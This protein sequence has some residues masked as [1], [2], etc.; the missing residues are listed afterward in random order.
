MVLTLTINKLHFPNNGT[1]DNPITV[2]LYYKEYYGSDYTLIG[3]GYNVDVDGTITDSPLPTISVNTDLKYVL[4]AV[5]ELCGFD[6]EQPVIINPYCPVNY[7]LSEDETLCE[8]SETV[9]AI[10]PTDP[11]NTVAATVSTY[12]DCGSYIYDPGYN[13][14][15]TGSS[16]QIPVLNTFWNNG[17]GVCTPGNT[18]DGP[19]N[20]SGLWAT[21]A[22]ADQDIG[23]SICVN[24]PETKTYYIGMGCD[25]YGILRIDGQTIIEQNEA[26]LDAQYG[27][28]G[29]PFHVWH[30]YPVELIAGE[31][32]IELIGHNVSPPAAMGAEIYDNTAA[33][34]IAATS[35]AGL[36][37]IFSTKDEI[38]NPVQLGTN[39]VGYTCPDGFSL[40][41]CD[42]PVV[43][44]KV[45]TTPVLY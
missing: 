3:N 1:I 28:G 40:A 11:E 4:R 6:Y 18:T 26:A 44:R 37:L 35:Y 22:V 7:Y 23:F 20:R 9:L 33:E 32:V 2:S 15:G 36:N 34:I 21:T 30:I 42:S 5:N 29:A 39:G 8:L 38:G 41:Y 25:N 43:C 12:S 45:L 19:L 17:G 24:I 10:P 14:D 13:F 16:T 31:R 27:I